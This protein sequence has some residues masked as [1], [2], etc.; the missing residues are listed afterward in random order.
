MIK[1]NS[2]YDLDGIPSLKTAIP[3]G[4]Q[5]ILAMFVSNLTP[6][7]I[8]AGVLGIPNDQKTMLIQATMLVAGFNTLIQ[9][10]TL[11]PIGARLPIVVGTSF[12]FVPVAISIGTKYGFQGVLGAAFV[13]GLFE[14]VLGLFIKRIRKYFPPI[15]TG[16]VVLSI[17][18]SLLPVGVKSF[19]GGVGAPD[20]G[21]MDNLLLGTI[22]LVTVIFFKQFTKGIWSTGSIFI[23]T[24]VGFIAAV[25][26]GKVNLAPMADAAYFTLPKPFMFG[27][28][29]HLDAILAMSLMYVVSAVETVGDMAGV[30]MG[31]AGRETTDRELSG[32]IMADGFGSMIAAAFSI[33]PTTSFSQNTGIIAMTGIMSRFVVAVGAMFLV[34]GAFIPK[35]GALFTIIPASVIGGSLIMVFAMITISGINLI[36]KEELVGKNAIIL[37]VS[38][39]LG[40]GLGSVPDALVH[41]PDSI[42]LIFGGYGIVISGTI[43]VVLNLVLPDKSPEAAPAV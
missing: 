40:Y 8:V 12:A 32:G 5:H 17:G 18:L 27:L 43:A 36:T 1:N 25:F 31:G 22:V 38:L 23:G 9:A 30:T 34:I 41:F 13:G 4:L 28:S 6:I 19:A 37:A 42:K 15:V 39:G 33:L 21:S 20:F 16:V 11:G 2:P 29:F 26:M 10:Y 35:I 24:I 3:L 7:M 14:A